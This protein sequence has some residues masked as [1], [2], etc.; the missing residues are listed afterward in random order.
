[1]VPPSG[2]VSTVSAEGTVKVLKTGQ[3]TD[4][5]YP[6][7]ISGG[8]TKEETEAALAVTSVLGISW[9]GDNNISREEIGDFFNKSE[10]STV[11]AYVDISDKWKYGGPY[12]YD[13]PLSDINRY[14]LFYGFKPYVANT[15]YENAEGNECKTNEDR[16]YIKGAWGSLD[17]KPKAKI[18]KAAYAGD[19]LGITYDLSEYDLIQEK[20]IEHGS[21]TAIFNKTAEGS[22][23]LKEIKEGADQN[24]ATFPVTMYDDAGKKYEKGSVIPTNGKATYYSENPRPSSG[25]TLGVDNNSYTHF[26]EKETD[27][28]YE[29]KNRD[30]ND[31]KLKETLL[32]L[33][34]RNYCKGD[35]VK[36]MEKNGGVC[37]GA[38]ETIALVK[39]RKLPL[40][41]LST[42]GASSYYKLPRPATDNRFN[43]VL[44][45]FFLQQL[46]PHVAEFEAKAL[47]P[48]GITFGEVNGKRRYFDLT[49]F[50]PILIKY[51]KAQSSEKQEFILGFQTEETTHAV[52]VTDI[53]ERENNYE[54]DIYD[55]NSVSTENPKGYMTKMEV[56]K[57]CS[58][59]TLNTAG[60]TVSNDNYIFIG[61]VDPDSF[62]DL[63][64][65]RYDGEKSHGFL[66]PTAQFSITESCRFTLNSKGKNF[67]VNNGRLSGDLPIYDYTPI[68]AGQGKEI[69][70]AIDDSEDYELKDIAG[71]LD[72]SITNSNGYMALKGNSINSATLSPGKT[73]DINGSNFDFKFYASTNHNVDE[74]S[75][76]LISVSGTAEDDISVTVKDDEIKMTSNGDISNIVAS[77]YVGP[78]VKRT[79]YDRPA[80]SMTINDSFIGESDLPDLSL[81]KRIKGWFHMILEKIFG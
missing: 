31:T 56:N 5:D 53:L 7:M 9:G 63:D 37:F 46:I 6:K 4:A 57:E 1:M 79:N 48:S 41:S 72:F 58:E 12:D 22:F 25:F 65:K 71:K 52:L 10:T 33:A 81:W 78:E 38:V 51:A 34:A 27:G 8:L 2:N 21:Y 70:L 64:G 50:L 23:S 30:I 16:L 36:E 55:I 69:R 49:V 18:S 29:I 77:K 68:F 62:A 61:Y 17:T 43:N 45:Y 59:F 75:K 19:S 54:L 3:L 35:I 13:I 26:Y 66:Q 42:S 15:I 44:Q 14:R 60:E 80:K 67:S 73:M 11:P 32:E 40:K 74:N 39:Q 76:G 28:F 20:N 47:N 24:K